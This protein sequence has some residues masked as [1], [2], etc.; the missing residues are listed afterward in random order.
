MG[1]GIAILLTGHMLALAMLAS[2]V[3]GHVIDH[4]TVGIFVVVYSWVDPIN[5]PCSSAHHDC[6]QVMSPG[7]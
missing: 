7:V 6:Q 2:H 1:V 4:V 3:I 5:T